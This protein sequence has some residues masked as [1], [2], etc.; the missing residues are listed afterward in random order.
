VDPVARHVGKAIDELDGGNLEWA[1]LHACIAVDGSAS[2][3]GRSTKK[4]YVAF[5]RKNYAVLQAAGLFGLDCERSRFPTSPDLPDPTAGDNADVADLI[6]IVHRCMRAHGGE[7]P[8]EY[9]LIEDKAGVAIGFD[10]PGVRLPGSLVYGLL[11]V[12]VLCRENRGLR[13]ENDA[14]RLWWDPPLGG[15]R[16]VMPVNEW[17]G[18]RRD[19]LELVTRYPTSAVVVRPDETWDVNIGEGG[20]PVVVTSWDHR[21][22]PQG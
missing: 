17:W 14:A 16:L 11:F 8:P 12:V 18:R 3:G 4:Q 21:A 13:V 19:F 10:P 2:R 9:A 15:E 1:M 5:L 6:Y 22:S 7:V 20:P